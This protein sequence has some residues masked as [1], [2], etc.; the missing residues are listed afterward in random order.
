MRWSEKTKR[1]MVAI[2]ITLPVVIVAISWTT[3]PRADEPLTVGRHMT[4]GR[5]MAMC[6][7]DD[8]NSSER[9]LC[10]AYLRGLTDGVSAANQT[11]DRNPPI[12]FCLPGDAPAEFLRG[13]FMGYGAANDD[14]SDFV[15]ALA[16]G[17]AI[18]LRF[19]C[20]EEGAP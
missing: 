11:R 13:V 20:E 19:P 9:V 6:A 10:G 8:P 17:L 12:D 2:L 16:I 15:A 5:L 4:V 14:H 3:K 18:A 1:W 7:A